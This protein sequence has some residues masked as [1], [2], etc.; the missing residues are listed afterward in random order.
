M[1]GKIAIKTAP[2]VEPVTTAE[3]KA[4][5]RVDISDD[6]TLIAGLVTAARR[7]IEGWTGIR[8]ITQTWY[9]YLD[10]FPMEEE[11]ILPIGPVSAVSSVKYM[12]QDDSV[13]STMSAS[14]YVTDLVGLPA[15]ITLKDSAS[16]PGDT[17]RE[18]NGVV[19]EFVAGYG[20]A[21][22]LVAARAALTAAEALVASATAETL[23]AAQ[24]ALAAAQVAVT[25]AEAAEAVEVPE[26][27]KLAVKMMVEHYYEHRGAVTELKIEEAPLAVQSLV[28]S[29]D[30]GQ[31]GYTYCAE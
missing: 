16:W 26:E 24:V 23:A 5:L 30:V 9:Y 29:F 21:S 4:H 27:L 25:A 3:A 17:L 2:T 6:D 14:D 20:N 22:D 13:L 12:K 7:L 18:V 10:C 15:R 28:A 19:I 31:R 1:N 11:I 8:M